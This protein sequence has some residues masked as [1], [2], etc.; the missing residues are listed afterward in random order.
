MSYLPDRIGHVIH[1]PEDVC[2]EIINR[3]IGLELNLSCNVH[4]KLTKGSF[5]DHHF[6]WWRGKGCPIALGV[7]CSLLLVGMAVS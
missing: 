2:E 7:C 5:G 3:K 4:A 1:V 6:G